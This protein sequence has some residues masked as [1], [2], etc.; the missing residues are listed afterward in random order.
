[1]R[2]LP[3]LVLCLSAFG[4]RSV[5]EDETEEVV[6]VTVPSSTVC[7]LTQDLNHDGCNDAV[8]R[9]RLPEGSELNDEVLS[10]DLVIETRYFGSCTNPQDLMLDSECADDPAVT[11]G[12]GCSQMTCQLPSGSALY[13]CE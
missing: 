13:N 11:E 8:C 7:D 12:D 5:P 4:C 9:M 3:L 1:M 6:V 2:I 10:E